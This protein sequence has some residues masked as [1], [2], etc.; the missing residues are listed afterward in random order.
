MNRWEPDRLHLGHSS[1]LSDHPLRN[2]HQTFWSTIPDEIAERTKQRSDAACSYLRKLLSLSLKRT[3]T[4]EQKLL[5]GLKGRQGRQGVTL[6]PNH[7]FSPPVPVGTESPSMTNHVNNAD[8][9]AKELLKWTKRG[10]Q[11]NLAVHV[12]VAVLADEMEPEEARKA[13]LAAAKEQG[14]LVPP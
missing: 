7:W 9:A 2:F 8:A 10:P 14:I 13:F 6:M 12:C 3:L 4:D 11:W 1:H 5:R